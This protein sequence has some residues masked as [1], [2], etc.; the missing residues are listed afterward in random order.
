MELTAYWQF[1]DNG[2][3]MISCDFRGGTTQRGPWEA[4]S[5]TYIWSNSRIGLNPQGSPPDFP[6]IVTKLDGTEVDVRE[7]LYKMFYGSTEENQEAIE[8]MMLLS[9]EQLFILPI[10]E[11]YAPMKIH[12]PNLAYPEDGNDPLWYMGH[13][14]AY[15]RLLKS[16]ALYFK[17]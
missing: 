7:Q 9:N 14:R 2:D 6:I 3:A 5:G 8:T 15:A 11:K 4:F 1:I 17:D 12:N 16:G 10:G 13:M